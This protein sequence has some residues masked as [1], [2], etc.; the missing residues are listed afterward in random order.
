MY[1]F[2]GNKN[3]RLLH[4]FSET[5]CKKFI[6][7]A[8]FITRNP[9]YSSALHPPYFQWKKKIGST[10]LTNGPESS[11]PMTLAD[12]KL[13]LLAKLTGHQ[14]CIQNFGKKYLKRPLLEQNQSDLAYVSHEEEVQIGRSL[15]VPSVVD[16]WNS[17]LPPGC[18]QLTIMM[19]LGTCFLQMMC[20]CEAVQHFAAT[21][22][23][24][25]AQWFERSWSHYCIICMCMCQVHCA[26]P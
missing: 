9:L 14:A 26:R 1:L 19:L 6:Y 5:F 22:D 13:D 3:K 15:L 11:S 12:M 2:I 21:C 20:P 18:S 8:H 24:F 10:T 7:T 17:S 16:M 25:S 4:F 23:Q